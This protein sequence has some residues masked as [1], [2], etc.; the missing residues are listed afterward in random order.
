MLNRNNFFLKKWTFKKTEIV[1]QKKKEI[2]N[3]RMVRGRE[4]MALFNDQMDITN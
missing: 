4:V 2:V 3:G 1:C